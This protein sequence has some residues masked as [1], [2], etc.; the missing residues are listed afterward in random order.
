[1]KPQLK[2]LSLA[3]LS[4]LASPVLATN[5]M[6]PI[7]IG[8]SAKGSGGAGV[9]YPQDSLVA[10]LNPAG[11]VHVGSRLDAG[12]ELFRPDRKFTGNFEADGS[13]ADYEGNDTTNFYVPEFGYNRMMS[14]DF[15]FGV[16]VFGNG[17]MNTDYGNHPLLGGAAG[18]NLEQLFIT[19]TASGKLGENYS[20]GVSLVIA[21]Q[22]FK[23]EGLSLLGNS[24]SYAS[25][26]VSDNGTDSSTGIG[27]RLGWMGKI[28][29]RLSLGATYQPKIRMSEMSKYKGLLAGGTLDIPENYALGMAFAVN[30]KF[31]ILFDIMRIE[32]KNVT[33]M[34]NPTS[35]YGG[36]LGMSSGP[37]FGWMNQTIYK[38]GVVY[39]HSN[40]LTLRAGLNFGDQNVPNNSFNDYFFNTLAPGVIRKHLTLGGTY[41]LNEKGS[42]TVAYRHAFEETLSGNGTDTFFGSGAPSGDL[43][44]SQDALGVSYNH[45]F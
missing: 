8:L 32:Y 43:T 5:G 6:A 42:I 35:G 16:S 19:P 41:K 18:I 15:S 14:D 25:N 28:N 30:P 4:T 27:V 33:A 45:S 23:A 36:A 3:V 40:T 12:L 20:I 26:S 13:R 39:K 37:G 24:L 17:G 9:A 11:M 10:G 31:D 21:Y 22:R 2:I 1:M 7:G 29:D 34:G 44:M 38:L